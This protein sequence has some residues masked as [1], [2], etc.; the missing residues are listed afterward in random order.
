LNVWVSVGAQKPFYE[1]SNSN[2]GYG[3]GATSSGSSNGCGSTNYGGS[4]VAGFIMI[5]DFGP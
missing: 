4:G 1:Y 3:G 2:Y 5:E